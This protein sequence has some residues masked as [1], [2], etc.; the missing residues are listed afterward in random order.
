MQVGIEQYYKEW[1]KGVYLYDV[2]DLLHV[3][4]WRDMLYR[5]S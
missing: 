4:Q 2:L 1:Q 5:L 3:T